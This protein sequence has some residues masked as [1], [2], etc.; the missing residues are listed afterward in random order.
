MPDTPCSAEDKISPAFKTFLSEAGPQDRRE[1]IVVYRTPKP[2]ETPTN[3]N[4]LEIRRRLAQVRSHATAQAKAQSKLS[5]EVQKLDK[6]M[7]G[8]PSSLANIGGKSLPIATMQVTAKML[9]ELARRPDVVAIM[10][11]QRVRLIRPRAV[12]YSRL[13]SQQLKD[14]LTWGLK[15]LRVPDVRTTSKGKGVRVAVMDTGVY[16]EQPALAGRVKDFV[17]IDSAGRRITTSAPFDASNHGTHVCGTI[18]GGKIGNKVAIG[19]AP[20]AELLVAAVLV[21]DST[22]QMLLEGIAWAVE[23]GANI[24]S[25]SL[26]FD[27]YEPLFA[28]IFEDLLDYGIIPVVAIGNENHGN[29][30]SPG[31]AWNALAVGAVEKMPGRKVDVAPF[32]SGASLVFP[33]V[34]PNALVHKPDVVAPGVQVMS[35]TPPVKRSDGTYDYSY[36]D[37]SSMA[38][39][40]V[41]GVAALLMSA[42]PKTP[43]RDIIEVIKT[44]AK[45]SSQTNRPDNRW[46]YGIVQPLEALKALA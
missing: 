30:S 38:T 27:Y 45:H 44:T 20:E 21:G 6:K 42:K 31:N 32:S 46:G 12:N 22:L 29:S 35:S 13:G 26:G 17:L 40:H 1:G 8:E 9:P 11:N 14:G 10:P 2:V 15:Q 4:I 3:G 39:P 18:A 33:G 16:G 5:D 23:T 41:A 7:G 25:M 24:L 34:E 19:V 36:M 43:A 37:G 28:T